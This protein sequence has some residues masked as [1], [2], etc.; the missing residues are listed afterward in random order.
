MQHFK[1]IESLRDAG[2]YN[3]VLHQCPR[4]GRLPLLCHSE[5]WQRVSEITDEILR[6]KEQERI[7]EQLC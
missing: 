6:R 7:S 1:T 2:W 5:R 3:D 4:I